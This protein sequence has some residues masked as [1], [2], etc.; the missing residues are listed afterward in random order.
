MKIAVISDLH[1]TPSG[2]PNVFGHAD[3]EFLGFLGFLEKNFERILLVG[4]TWETLTGKV[5]YCF[6]SIDT[7]AREFAVH[8]EW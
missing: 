4:D 1:L 5:R 8:T 2:A 7:R 3:A 6:L